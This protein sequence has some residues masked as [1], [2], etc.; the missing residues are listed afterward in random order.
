LLYCVFIR[1]MK[2][3]IRGIINE[4]VM[5]NLISGFFPEM[6]NL[7]RR[8]NYNQRQYGLNTIYYNKGDNEYYF[9]VSEPARRLV[10]GFDD[11]G[12]HPEYRYKDFKKTLY[13]DL[14]L[15]NEILKWVN[16]ENMILDWFN[17]RYG[18]NAEVIVPF[19]RLKR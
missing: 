19:N 10:W 9:R 11:E 15:Y 7:K 4:T 6:N 14:R 17:S 5:E 3:V 8:Q 2:E 13:I 16:N 1:Y 12:L 18:E